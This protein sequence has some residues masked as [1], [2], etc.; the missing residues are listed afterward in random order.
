[1]VKRE[2]KPDECTGILKA[3]LR[4]TSKKVKRRK[5]NVKIKG[6]GEDI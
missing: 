2:T 4:I 1:M 5:I 6:K 3:V